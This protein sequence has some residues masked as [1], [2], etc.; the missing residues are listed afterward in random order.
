MA[1]YLGLLPDALHS[2]RNDVP[3]F[4]RSS[5]ELVSYRLLL[6]D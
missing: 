5:S 4:Q 3:E 1:E 6:S 2:T